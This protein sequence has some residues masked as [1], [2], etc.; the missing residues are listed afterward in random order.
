MSDDQQEDGQ[1]EPRRGKMSAK[2]E[3]QKFKD[4]L[5]NTAMDDSD[6]GEVC[7]RFLMWQFTLDLQMD[8]HRNLCIFTIQLQ[9]SKKIA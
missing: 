4:P 8:L 5:M 9:Y 3:K 7:L 6:E 2:T 1:T